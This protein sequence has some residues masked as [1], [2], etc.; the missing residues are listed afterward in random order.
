L[1]LEHLAAVPSLSLPVISFVIPAPVPIIPKSLA[2]FI[3][4]IKLV[5]GADPPYLKTL[6]LRI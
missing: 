3:A 6:R 1:A 4:D 2:L 5:E